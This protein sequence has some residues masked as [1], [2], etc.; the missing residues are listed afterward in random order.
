M[1]LKFNLTTG[2][3][4]FVNLTLVGEHL[5]TFKLFFAKEEVKMCDLS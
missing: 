5:W 1:T 3:Y 2:E 4:L